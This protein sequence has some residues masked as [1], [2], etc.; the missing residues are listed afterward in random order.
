M[1]ISILALIICLSIL[2]YDYKK[3]NYLV[4]VNPFVWLLL[5][6]LLY[7]IVPSIFTEG[8]NHYFDWGIDDENILYT[9]IVILF[10]ALF[11]S[12]LLLNFNSTFL[13]ITPDSY[14]Y[15]PWI[16]YIIWFFIVIYVLW[17]LKI[18]L[19]GNILKSAFIYDADAAKD[20]HKLK[21]IAYLLIPVSTYI[22]FYQ[23]KYFVFIPNILISFI[24]MFHGSRTTALIC[25]I[26]IILSVVIVNKKIYLPQM[27]ILFSILIIIGIVRSNNVVQDVPW[28]LNAIGEFRETYITLPKYITNP[29]YIGSGTFFGYIGNLFF[30]LLHPLRGTIANSYNF[31]GMVLANDINRGYGLGA[32]LII[33]ALYY[34]G[35]GLVLAL[36][37]LSSFCLFIYRVVQQQ[38]QSNIVVLMSLY[39]IFIRLIIREGATI[40]ISLFIFIL[41]LYIVPIMILR[42]VKI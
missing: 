34:S 5:L 39:I 30:G 12:V 28:Y 15:K 41:V 2:I 24:D 3:S 21:N 29:N 1:I 7:F 4:V 16:L 17:V 11:F 40:Y 31:P 18:E 27:I 26:P 14:K 20:P 23:K 36:F 37:L 33:D 10:L 6:F 9:R 22:F 35:I 42:K 13:S 25:F 8:I 38:N 19:S 32:N